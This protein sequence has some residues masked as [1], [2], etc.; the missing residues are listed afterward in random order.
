VQFLRGKIFKETEAKKEAKEI[1]HF[2]ERISFNF[3][4]N[5]YNVVVGE[6]KTQPEAKTDNLVKTLVITHFDRKECKI[7]Y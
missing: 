6:F 2:G 7:Y 4:K 1:I 5:I 3:M